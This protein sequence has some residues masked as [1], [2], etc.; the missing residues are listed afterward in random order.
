[1]VL[2]NSKKK[3]ADQIKNVEYAMNAI[4]CCYIIIIRDRLY[5][6]NR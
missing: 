2:D 5:S 3:Q 4:R 1:M 6:L